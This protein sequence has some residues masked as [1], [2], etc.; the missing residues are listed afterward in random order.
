MLPDFFCF[1]IKPLLQIRVLLIN[2]KLLVMN[3]NK[4]FLNRSLII[5][6]L[7]TILVLGS[8]FI[9]NR[10]TS[11]EFLGTKTVNYKL[12][13]D[14]L[15]VTAK[16][17]AFTKLKLQ[18][19][20]GSLNMHK[21][22]VQYGNGKKEEINLKHNFN[23][24]SDSRVIDLNGGKRIIRDITFIYDTKDR[25]RRRAEVHVYGRH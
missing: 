17:G 9:S 21:M 24:R 4:S 5:T 3:S 18:V 23:R 19:T 2:F 25:S 16:E 10:R 12:D 8:G 14:V 1:N 6:A 22:I 7:A 20:G 15:R 11:W 13:R